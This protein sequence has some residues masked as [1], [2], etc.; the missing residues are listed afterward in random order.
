MDSSTTYR[1]SIDGLQGLRQENWPMLGEHLRRFKFK[2]ARTIAEAVTW[3]TQAIFEMGDVEINPEAP[4][5]LRKTIFM[6]SKLANI[7][8]ANKEISIRDAEA[9]IGS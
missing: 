7:M 9:H 2:N 8:R 5:W 6:A 1:F 4:E 3:V